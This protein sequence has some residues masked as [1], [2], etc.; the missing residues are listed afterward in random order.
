[1]FLTRVFNGGI[2]DE[3]KGVKVRTMPVRERWRAYSNIIYR[4][5]RKFLEPLHKTL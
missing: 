2:E 5:G 3:H 1:M 4:I